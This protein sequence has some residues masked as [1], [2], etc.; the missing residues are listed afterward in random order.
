VDREQALGGQLLDALAHGGL[1][2]TTLLGDD[3]HEGEARVGGQEA[4]L[5]GPVVGP[6]VEPAIGF[7]LDE[8]DSGVGQDG[9]GVAGEAGR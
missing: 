9:D 6:L 5:H 4:E 2:S 3:R 8:D 7:V 1:A